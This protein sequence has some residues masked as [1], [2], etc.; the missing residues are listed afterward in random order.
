MTS[1]Y[2]ARLVAARLSREAHVE[3]FGGSAQTQVQYCKAHGINATTFSGWL[4]SA[5]ATTT[6]ALMANAAVPRDEKQAIAQRVP[7][8]V[9][10]VGVCA[11]APLTALA[12]RIEA[13]TN[14]V[15]TNTVTTRIATARAVSAPACPTLVVRGLGGWAIDIDAS[16]PACAAVAALLHALDRA[17]RQMQTQTQTHAQM[18]PAA[19]HTP[20]P[21][22]GYR[23]ESHRSRTQPVTAGPSA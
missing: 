5:R 19:T 21:P 1:S 17:E 18:S 4:R 15:T 10:R 22:P 8:A 11:D 2:R 20:R 6:I 3:A 12:V 23:D 9:K 14:T 7:D 13:A 16:E